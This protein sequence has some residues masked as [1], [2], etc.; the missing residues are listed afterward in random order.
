MSE[1]AGSCDA[2]FAGVREALRENVASRGELGAAVAAYIDGRPVIDLWAGW[3]DAG[4]TRPWAEDT[5]VNV[6][7]V[8]KAFAAVCLLRLVAGGSV[9]LEDPVRRHWPTF[10][11]DTTIGEVLS[12]RAGLAAIA[13]PLPE[14]ALFDWPAMT[15]ALAAQAP[16]WPPG[17]AHGYHVHTF[18]FLVGELVRRVTGTPID[19]ALARE[20]AE[21]LAAEVWFGLPVAERGRRA[22]YDFGDMFVEAPPVPEPPW[23][24]STAAYVNPPGATGLGTVNT[25]AWMDATIPSANAHATARGVAQVYAA[26]PALLDRDTLAVATAEHASGR[27][28]VLDRPTRFGL[29]FQLTQPERPLGPGPG[30]YGH[31]GAGGSVGFADPDNGVAFAYVMNRGGPRWQSPRTRA[32]IDALYDAL[33]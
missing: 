20:I 26:L 22:D 12:H 5:V 23:E 16:W 30:G 27:D 33:I 1:I 2:R 3:T 24:L 29:G 9:G 7:S 15:Q 25:S 8:G 17:T 4:R 19:V 14:A 13:E 18:G 10:A 28:L 6:F 21:P 11:T 32:L 31:F